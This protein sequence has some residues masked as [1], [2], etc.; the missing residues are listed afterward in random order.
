VNLILF[1]LRLLFGRHWDGSGRLMPLALRSDG[2]THTFRRRGWFWNLLRALREKLR[3]L[4]A[5]PPPRRRRGGLGLAPGGANV[6][7]QDE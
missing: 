2:R 1:I 3:E 4:F 7:R 5:E 6:P